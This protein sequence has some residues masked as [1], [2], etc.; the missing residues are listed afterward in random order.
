MNI[1]MKGE[2]KMKRILVCMV[3][4]LSLTATFPTHAQDSLNVTMIGRI[5]RGN[6]VIA[7]PSNRLWLG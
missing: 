1:D 6:P 7:T 3:F 4:L 5:G 2:G